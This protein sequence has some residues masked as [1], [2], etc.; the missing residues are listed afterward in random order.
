MEP[1]KI[2]FRIQGGLVSPPYPIHLD[3]LL[4]YAVTM[5]RLDPDD[6]PADIAALREIANDLPLERY[7]QDGEWVWK[8]SALMPLGT[9]RNT[10]RFF[11]QRLDKKAYA[12]HVGEGRI[13]LGRYQ[14]DPALPP[15]AD[16]APYQNKIDTL[17]GAHRNLLG[18][19]PVL[20]VTEVEA[21]CVGDRDG[22]EDY[23]VG[24]GLVTHIGARRR[25]GHGQVSAVCIQSAPDA[26]EMWKLRVRPWQMLEN[27]AQIQAAW[28]APYW[29]TEN[30]GQAFCPISLI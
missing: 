2:T 26:E 15:G 16:M 3:A 17:R 11:T 6:P 28:R 21:W 20:D 29:A 10:S 1:L 8:A 12:V 4:A 14:P 30:K 18:F 19:Y 7:E 9:I 23:L 22:I 25:S 13:Q 24:R 5:A 27:D